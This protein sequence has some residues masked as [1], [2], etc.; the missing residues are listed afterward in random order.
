[1]S[2]SPLAIP[3]IV[4]MALA[5]QLPSVADLLTRDEV[6]QAEAL[7]D[8]QPRTAE[9][10]ALRGEI[11]YRKGNFDRA[12]ALYKEALGMNAKT[13][14]A[15]YGLGKLAIGKLK[16]KQAIQEMMRAIELDPKE[17]LYRFYA[18]EA[19]ALEKNYAEQRKQIEEYIA[20]N[21]SDPD[22]LAEAKAGLEM[23][24]ALGNDVASVDAPQNPA[25]I[26]LRKSLNL[27]FARVMINGRGPYEFA[28]DT[29]ASQIVLS[30]KL[31]GDLGLTPVTSTI[32]HGVGGGGKID[33]KLYSV[34]EMTI[35]DVKI[36]NV[37]VGTFNDPL[38][39]QLADGI[40]STAV[41]SDFILTVNYPG[42]QLEI[43]RSAPQQTP[44][45][46]F[47]Q[48]GTSAIFCLFPSR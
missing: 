30:E 14:R 34:K 21:P 37:P 48:P 42:N 38:V 43:S 5:L 8:K 13:A 15:H 25:P 46:R 4:L 12:G 19:W 6:Q 23:L 2:S 24:K 33:T 20:L 35:G 7:L 32:M 45:A 26:P 17:P 9:S 18:S 3:L 31:A 16:T 41:L 44:R 10:V 22:R 11:E 29:G 28:V 1:M 40:F 36:K 39:S 27:V 47:F